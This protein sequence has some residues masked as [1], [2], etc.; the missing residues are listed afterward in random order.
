MSVQPTEDEYRRFYAEPP[1]TVTGLWAAREDPFE[2][3]LAGLIGFNPVL[4]DLRR[5]LG[6]GVEVDEPMMWPHP[7]VTLHR[8][9]PSP[10]DYD[11]ELVA[12]KLDI[13]GATQVRSGGHELTDHQAADLLGIPEPAFSR[14]HELAATGL[15]AGE[16][17]MD[18]D[19]PSA[20][21]GPYEVVEARTPG[22]APRR[23]PA[24]RPARPGRGHQ[25]RD[26]SVSIE[27]SVHR[28]QGK[29]TPPRIGPVRLRA[30]AKAHI[31]RTPEQQERSVLSRMLPDGPR[32]RRRNAG[33]GR[34]HHR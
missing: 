8:A 22:A 31:G 11:G 3:N 7:E 27:P 24:S 33:P 23:R 28:T 16:A 25:R 5:T 20:G 12:I 10:W 15:R 4:D 26:Q 18:P 29:P 30:A 1:D 17:A 6:P 21:T 32:R 2:L 13:A 19:A 14:G 9:G 34:D